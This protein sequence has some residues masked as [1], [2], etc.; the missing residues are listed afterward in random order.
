MPPCFGS[1]THLAALLG[2]TQQ[3]TSATPHDDIKDDQDDRGSEYWMIRSGGGLAG[4][5]LPA[6]ALPSLHDFISEYYLHRPVDHLLFEWSQGRWHTI[7][8]EDDDDDQE[9][10]GGAEAHQQQRQ[11]RRKHHVS[12]FRTHEN[13]WEHIGVTSSLAHS[14]A[15]Q[16]QSLQCN[17]P[18]GDASCFESYD[19]RC[20]DYGNGLSPCS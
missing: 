15:L 14:W 7:P 9:P 2:S 4:V 12:V 5:L 1:L 13:L 19:A 17:R 11:G 6:T 3:A 8:D 16:D 18:L 20:L 10:Q